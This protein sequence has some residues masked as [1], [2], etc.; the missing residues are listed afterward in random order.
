MRKRQ[1]YILIL[2][3]VVA[4]MLAGCGVEKE[5]RAE[6]VTSGGEGNPKTEETKVTDDSEGM[7]YYYFHSLQKEG[8]LF[9]GSDLLYVMDYATGERVPVCN[10]TNCNHLPQSS[11]NPKPECYAAY[12][13]I[14]SP[15]FLYRDKLYVF[16]T[17]DGLNTVVYC[18]ERTGEGRKK[19][20]EGNFVIGHNNIYLEHGRLYFVAQENRIGEDHQISETEHYLCLFD[21]EQK[22][23]CP[24]TEKTTDLVTMSSLIDDDIYYD[25]VYSE[26]TE[27]GSR[28]VQV[29]YLRYATESGTIQEYVPAENSENLRFTSGGIYYLC[30]EE[31]GYDLYRDDYKGNREYIGRVENSAQY[32]IVDGRVLLRDE[33]NSLQKGLVF[34]ASDGTHYLV[35]DDRKQDA[36][37]DPRIGVILAEDYWSGNDTVVYME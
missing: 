12:S 1:L 20:A 15:A 27:D 36:S 16:V 24:L 13:G 21:V 30:K 25:I 35:L 2:A 8:L 29:R 17:E 22:S 23:F 34:L 26:E 33:M 11:T 19:I 28:A 5:D 32:K 37:G 31:Q 10:R 6:G 18:S 14:I 3:W 9:Y 4:C 7:G